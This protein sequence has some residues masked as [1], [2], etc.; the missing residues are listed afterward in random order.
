M[1]PIDITIHMPVQVATSERGTDNG[2]D[3]EFTPAIFYSR[4][5]IAEAGVSTPEH[6]AQQLEQEFQGLMRDMLEFLKAEFISTMTEKAY[7]T[8]LRQAQDVR[9]TARDSVAR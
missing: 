9:A 7:P 3:F 1:H 8:I 5:Q 4:I 6:F 2:H